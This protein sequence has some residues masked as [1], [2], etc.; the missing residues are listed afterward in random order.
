M[1][2][3]WL[4]VADIFHKIVDMAYDERIVLDGGP[5]ISKAI[6][7]CEIEYTMPG[8]SQLRNAWSEFRD[9]GHLIAASAYLAHAALAK[10][11]HAASI[12]KALW[13]APDAVIALA[14]GFQEFWLQHDS[15]KEARQT[16]QHDNLWQIPT[17]LIPEKPF[18][19]FRR[20]SEEQIEYLRTR[21]AAKKYEPTTAPHR[22]RR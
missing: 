18:I 10:T 9:V 1:Q 3:K 22:V 15:G 8:H 4:L 21:R 7:V 13:I 16:L 5:S 6:E 17:G 20:L 19:V 2:R 11:P 12:L 14:C